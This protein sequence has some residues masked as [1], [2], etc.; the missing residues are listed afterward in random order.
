[1]G[2]VPENLSSGASGGLSKSFYKEVTF[3]IR[4]GEGKGETCNQNSDSHILR[5]DVMGNIVATSTDVS[6]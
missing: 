2:E 5:C 1:M 3:E 4:D 6:V